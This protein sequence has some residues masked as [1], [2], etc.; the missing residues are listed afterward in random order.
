[1]LAA[2]EICLFIERKLTMT[3]KITDDCIACG[4]CEAEC[5]EGAI[6]QQGDT[7][8]IDAA[9]CKDCGSCADVCPVGAPIPA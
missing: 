5:A 7:Y 3:Y 4:A 9:L 6:S 2:K 1:M 8:V